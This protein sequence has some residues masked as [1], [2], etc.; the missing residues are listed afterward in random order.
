MSSMMHNAG[1]KLPLIQKGFYKLPLDIV[2]PSAEGRG[3][4]KDCV[5]WVLR[6]IV[7]IASHLK[8][9]VQVTVKLSIC[10]L[11]SPRNK[12]LYLCWTNNDLQSLYNAN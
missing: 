3:E 10:A 11:I 8:E 9:I 12:H 7:S 2:N 4:S 6:E 1:T 5:K